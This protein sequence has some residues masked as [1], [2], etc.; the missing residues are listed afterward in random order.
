MKI[1]LVAI[2]FVLAL[3][4]VGPTLAEAASDEEIRDAKALL[5]QADKDSFGV[6]LEETRALLDKIERM[7]LDGDKAWKSLIM[8]AFNQ[9]W[10][11]YKKKS[12]VPETSFLV[13]RAYFYNGRPD[14]AKR[15]LKKTFYYNG[16]YVDAHIL[17][18]D[19]KLEESRNN[20][21]DNDG[22]DFLQIEQSRKS[23]EKVLLLEDVD[24]EDR[25][26][27]FMKIGDLYANMGLNKKKSMKYWEKSYDAAPESFWGERSNNRMTDLD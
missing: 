14:K 12:S 15:A 16:E 24:E 17:R 18:A 9:S 23:Y 4:T 26:K 8:K 11:L 13:A 5:R 1:F 2:V 27:V 22:I 3:I 19:I 7:Q 6:S 25:S 10:K 21:D 20:I